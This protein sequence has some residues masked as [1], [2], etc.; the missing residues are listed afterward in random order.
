MIGP[1]RPTGPH[2]PQ[3][4]A[5]D[6]YRQKE[7]HAGNFE[8]NDAANPTEGAEETANATGNATAGPDSGLSGSLDAIRCVCNG[9]GLSLGLI[10]SLPRRGGF[11]RSRQALPR[12]LAGNPQSRAK[13]AANKLSSHTV[14]DGS[15]DAG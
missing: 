1:V 14:Y 5:K 7:E 9:L 11:C 8:P 3:I 15:S 13:N 2:S 10:S 12:H 6:D 4:R